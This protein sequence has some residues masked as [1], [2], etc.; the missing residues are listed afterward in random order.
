MAK[1]S[2]SKLLGLFH[3]SGELFRRYVADRLTTPMTVSQLAVPQTTVPLAG[4]TPSDHRTAEDSQR[5]GSYGRRESSGMAE[6]ARRA[7]DYQ[8]ATDSMAREDDYM[9][10]EDDYGAS[11]DYAAEYR[12]YQSAQDY[13]APSSSDEDPP[14]PSGEVF[15]PRLSA[16]SP[17]SLWLSEPSED[18]LLLI[19]GEAEMPLDEAPY[20]RQTLTSQPM[21]S[22]RTTPSAWELVQDESPP[23]NSQ[24]MR[25]LYASDPFA[26]DLAERMLRNATGDT[27]DSTR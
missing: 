19:D 26:R 8:T 9:A 23:S 21:D 14:I 12:S 5:A 27:P 1:A 6:T 18:D 10:S 4:R 25:A 20:S 15:S 7:E 22:V 13:P 17:D 3:R 24:E 11:E 2:H 16:D